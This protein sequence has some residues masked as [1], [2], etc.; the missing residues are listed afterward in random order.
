M[1]IF[2]NKSIMITGATGSLGNALID[3]LIQKNPHKI[4]IYSRDELKQYNLLKKHEVIQKEKDIL[5]TFI[6][7]VRD[8]DR[9]MT[10]MQDVDIVVH[11]A[12][13]KQIDTAEYNPRE[14]IKTNIQGS[15]NVIECAIQNNVKKTLLISTDK[16]CNPCTLYG[17]TKAIAEKIF[18][19]ANIY[20]K[21]HEFKSMI[22][23]YGNVA[24]SRGSVIPFFK[25]LISKGDSVLPLTHEDMTRFYITLDKACEV[26]EFALNYGVAGE[27][28]IPKLKAFRIKDLIAA[29]GSDYKIVG[30]RGTEKLHEQMISQYEMAFDVGKYYIIPSN[31]KR[32][33]ESP[34]IDFNSMSNGFEYYSND[35]LMTTD[36][37]KKLDII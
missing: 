20:S 10:A 23:R 12:A 11:A 36:Q 25:D 37:I 22:V 6:G 27:I 13:L 3:Y 24:N 17:Y 34:Y 16:A 9:L 30:I 31:L 32:F 8:K 14:V 21:N 29:M 33:I 5:R 7:D 4:I 35:D 19:Q 15:E 18:Q 28:F 1:N 26:I 2:E